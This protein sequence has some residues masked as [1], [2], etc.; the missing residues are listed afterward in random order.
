M[1]T[2]DDAFFVP[3]GDAFIATELVRGPWDDRFAHGGPPSGLLG[4]A[5][6][7]EGARHGTPHVARLTVDLL[8]PVPIERLEVRS[9]IVRAGRAALVLS[10]SLRTGDRELARA[11]ALCLRTASIDV[12][13]NA[14]ARPIPPP[15]SAAPFS[16]PYFR[17]RPGYHRAM[18]LH[19]V[20]GTFGEGPTVGW[21]RMRVPLVRGETPSGLVRVLVAADS[22]NGISPVLDWRTHTF[23]NPDLSVMIHRA[24][25]GEWVGM[26]AST[27]VEPH[28]VGMAHSRLYDR[29]GPIGHA[30]QHLIL[31]AR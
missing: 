24:L 18:D 17:P 29:M 31:A 30:V 14:S 16:L 11:S 25:D 21:M 22:G 10:L 23:V 15:E 27:T 2:A 28:G 8:R 4:R 9:S 5:A 12:A 3:D 19:I 1:T 26:D 13:T 7:I 20:E 6:E